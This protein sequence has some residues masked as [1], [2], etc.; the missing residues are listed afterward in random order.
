M[1]PNHKENRKR[2]EKRQRTTPTNT[3][4]PPPQK[5]KKDDKTT[6]LPPPPP[7]PPQRPRSL[8]ITSHKFNSIDNTTTKPDETYFIFM[9]KTANNTIID[10]STSDADLFQ[11]LSH[12]K[13]R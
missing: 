2:T 11:L 10:E 13:L 8:S 1:D 12:G 5:P 9:D 7:P 6:D 4:Q 3:E